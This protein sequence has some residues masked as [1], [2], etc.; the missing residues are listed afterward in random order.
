MRKKFASLLL[1]TVVL[2]HACDIVEPP[3][4]ETKPNPVVSDSAVQKVVIEE[5]TGHLCP[6]CPDGAKVAHELEQLYPGR[7]IIISIH[8]GYFA[9]LQSPNYLTDYRSTVG[10]E[11]FNYFQ[12]TSYPIAMINRINKNGSPL[13]PKD[14]WAPL[15][16]SLVH[17]TPTIRIMY[18]KQFNQTSS[19]LQATI[20]FYFLQSIPNKLMWCAYVT[21]D[22]LVSYQ[23]NNNSNLGP[24]PDIP[25][26]RHDHVLR[27]SITG[28]WGDTLISTPTFAGDT[29]IK[30]IQY[31]FSSS[32][33]WKIDN[34]HVVIFVYDP[35]TKHIIQAE[36]FS[37]K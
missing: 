1:M 14:A 28:T 37:V 19:M 20:R 3:Y 10:N 25:N 8:A 16:D 23:K 27:A 12:P 34:T 35:T 2:F 26:Y 11:L 29:I 13:I 4:V 32:T 22:S 17:T 18:E 7:V 15:V 33:S 5:F 6:N 24:V 21:E 36:K 31:S 30:T 9:N